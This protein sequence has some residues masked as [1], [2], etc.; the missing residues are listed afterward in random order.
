MRENSGS[1]LTRS[2]PRTASRDFEVAAA[3]SP[4]PARCAATR[5]TSARPSS[6]SS[7]ARL[8]R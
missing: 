2:L 6:V 3:A 8:V 7:T 5:S 4:I 1:T